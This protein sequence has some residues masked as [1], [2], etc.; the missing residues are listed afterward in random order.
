MH[1]AAEALDAVSV[2]RSLFD[3]VSFDLIYARQEQSVKAWRAE[4]TEALSL[5][6]DH[7]SL[8]QL[9]IEPGT[10]FFDRLRK[11]GLRGLPDEDLGADLWEVT[12]E[13]CE[14]AGLPAYE[15]SNHA[16]P[17]SESRHNLTYWRNEDWVGIGPG[18]HGRFGLKGSRVATE[19]ET[20]P[21]AWISLVETTGSGETLRQSLDD[22]TVAE[23]ALMMGLRLREGVG[24]LKCNAI[25]NDEFL[26]QINLFQSQGLIAETDGVIRATES[27]RPVLNAILRELI[28]V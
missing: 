20:S 11:G 28:A 10:A 17:G 4:L 25:R 16:R 1:S 9:T 21:G 3:R 2:A 27:G 6:P 23:D 26:L 24:L 7:L 12:Q 19:S 14:V 15:I 18:A 13:A 8:Y 5:E 22:V